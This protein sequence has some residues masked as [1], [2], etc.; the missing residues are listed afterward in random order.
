[1]PRE[2]TRSCLRYL[3][4]EKNGVV[5]FMNYQ[6]ISLRQVEGNL[7]RRIAEQWMLV[8][9]GDESGYNMMTASW[10]GAGEMWGTD[11]AVAVVRPTRYTYEFLDRSDYFTLCFFDDVWKKRV[12]SVCGSQSG[13]DTDKAQ[14]TGLTPLFDHHSVRFA[15]A[16]LTLCLRKIY[17]SDLDP[18]NFLDPAI[19]KWYDGDYHRMYV[20]AVEAVLKKIG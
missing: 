17:V 9:A 5:L 15:Q 4:T 20:G 10:G 7:V 8:A 12:H 11:V 1:M 16:E 6:T 2:A 13:R 14:A 18:K 3:M 19:A